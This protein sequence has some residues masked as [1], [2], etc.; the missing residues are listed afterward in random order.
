MDNGPHA[1][2]LIRRFLGEVVPGEGIHSA[3]MFTS[4]SGCEI[5]ANALFR[6]PRQR[7]GPNCMRAGRSARAT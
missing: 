2:D 6:K 5:E 7:R 4:P 3:K 1:C